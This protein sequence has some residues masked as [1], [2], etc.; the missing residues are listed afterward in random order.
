MSTLT[1]RRRRLARD[2][3]R[4]GAA[5]SLVMFVAGLA[6][7]GDRGAS[8]AAVNA[9]T[10]ELQVPSGPTI[11]AVLTSGGS[12]TAF[13]LTPPTGA[14]CTGDS[15]TGGY[16]VQSYIVPSTVSP[17][18]LTFDSNGPAPAGTGA[19]LRLPLF[20]TTGTPIVDRTTAVETSPGSGGLITGMPTINFAVFGSS[21]PTVVPAGSY[22]IGFACTLGNP[23]PNQVD[24]YWNVVLTFA[25][26]PS[27]SPSGITW[28]VAGG[29]T[30]T[31]TAAP[32]T[33]ATGATTTTAAGA[34][35]TVAGATTTV[36]GDTT[37]TDRT[38]TT[39]LVDSGA[40]S[41]GFDN[42]GSLPVTGPSPIPIVVWGV[43]LLVFGR[44]A[45]LLA[46]PLKVIPYGAA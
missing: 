40:G 23:G 16:R 14:A 26:T 3:A 1:P 45:I 4:A 13:S 19:A 21:G 10:L 25:V 43:L 30:P 42:G 22:N 29:T 31:T 15:A 20:S 5:L 37:T 35:T 32:T 39:F 38:D 18:T 28:T 17:A 8:A 27:D 24:K 44:M 46:R 41:G 2:L 6:G 34:T 12:A 36:A 11:G 7:L 33:T 9:G